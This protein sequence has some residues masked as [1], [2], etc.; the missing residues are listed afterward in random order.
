MKIYLRGGQQWV[1]VRAIVTCVSS[2]ADIPRRLHRRSPR[3][4]TGLH[5]QPLRGSSTHITTAQR[6]RTRPSYPASVRVL[7]ESGDG[8]PQHVRV[9]WPLRPTTAAASHYPAVG[10]AIV[11]IVAESASAVPRHKAGGQR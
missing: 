9:H 10:A 3:M 7:I 1:L 8:T 6:R 5:Y 4:L 2:N 11:R